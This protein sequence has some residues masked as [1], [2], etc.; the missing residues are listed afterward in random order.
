MKFRLQEVKTF[1]LIFVLL[2]ILCVG[3]DY[4]EDKLIA[5]LSITGDLAEDLLSKRSVVLYSFSF[6]PKEINT[7]HENLV[8]TGIDAVAYFEIDKVLGGQDMTIAYSRYFL[9]REIANLIFVQ[10][11]STGYTVYV[12]PFNNED[13]LVKQGQAAWSANGPSLSE[14]LTTLYRAALAKNKQKN[15]LINE[16]PETD[17]SVLLIGGRRSELFAYDLKVDKLAIPK[18]GDIENDNML[19]E[20]LKTYP[21]PK[22]L[23]DNTVPESELRKK[24]FLYVLCYVHTRSSAAKSLL[25]Y[26]VSPSESAFASVT[27][28]DGQVQVKNIPAT[29]SV[30][31]FYVRHID[32][33][34]VFLGTKWDADTT[35]QQALKNFITAFKTELKI[36]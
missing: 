29:T 16:V 14:I 3:Q 11:T 36:N 33:G 19:E 28:P 10:K 21:L 23:V 25:G 22:E 2:P 27:Y 12:T 4:T 30:Y 1:A 13:D 34:N 15:L 18:F 9:K 32:S 31:K 20:L 7:I 6:T 5:R 26:T 8:Q 35:W 17:L 24:G